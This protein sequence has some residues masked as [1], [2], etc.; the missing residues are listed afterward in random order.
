MQEKGGPFTL[1]PEHCGQGSWLLKPLR[2]QPMPHEQVRDRDR[3]CEGR[4]QPTAAAPMRYRHRTGLSSMTYPQPALH[5]FSQVIQQGH[6]RHDGAAEG[7]RGSERRQLYAGV[8]KRTLIQ[9]QRY[10]MPNSSSARRGRCASSRPCLGRV[11]HDAVLACPASIFG[12]AHYE[13]PELRR[14]D[15]EPLAHVLTDPVSKAL[16]RT[17]S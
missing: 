15:V 14:H 16:T 1:S 17:P 12:S 8:G 6:R 5:H 11:M 4:F 13:E 3:G 2:W 10:A 9:Q 7:G